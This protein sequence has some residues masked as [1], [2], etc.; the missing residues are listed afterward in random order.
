MTRVPFVNLGAQFEPL[1][2]ELT[3][4]FQRICRSGQYIQGEEVTRFESGLAELC[5]SRFAISVANGTDALI[6][7]LKA[8]DIGPGDEV[9]TAP[10]SFI[11]S[12]GAIAAV[13]AEIRFADVGE[14]YNLDPIA[15]EAAITPKTRA[16]L[17]VHLTGN[18]ADMDALAAIAKP[19]GIHLIEDA[20]QAIDATYKGRKVGS[21]GDIAC[22][23][24]HPLKNL[25]LMGDAGFITT[26]DQ[27]LAERLGRLRNHGLINRDEAGEWGLNS[28]LDAMQAAFGN[29]KLRHLPRWTERFRQIAAYY[30][31]QFQGRLQSPLSRAEDRPVYHNLVLQVARRSALMDA[32][33]DVGIDTKIHYPIPLHLMRAARNLPYQRGSFPVTERQS[34]RILSLP[35]YPELT[36]TQVEYVAQQV[37]LQS[38][39]LGIQHGD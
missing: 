24:L 36:D 38:Q 7:A 35:I 5:D 6:L 37:L 15:V 4:V 18:P 33:A 11:A 27:A 22:F 34:E 17:A 14:D 3:E 9:I 10:N 29:I 19:R 12:A 23:S 1:E 39:R 2:A 30:L 20:A 13:G 32:L 8:L 26:S 31:E 16:I 25:H 21:L 28:R